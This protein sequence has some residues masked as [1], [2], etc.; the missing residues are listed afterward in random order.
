MLVPLV[1][2]R[3]S[4]QGAA[5]IYTSSFHSV[6]GSLPWQPLGSPVAPVLSV[7]CAF[8]LGAAR[9]AETHTLKDTG[10]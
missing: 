8:L 6:K 10:S 1:T 9:I 5:G 2:E 3:R 4:D 7:L